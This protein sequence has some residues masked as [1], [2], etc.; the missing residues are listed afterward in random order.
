MSYIGSPMSD[1]HQQPL[2][3][4]MAKVDFAMYSYKVRPLLDRARG[5]VE[6]PRPVGWRTLRHVPAVFRSYPALSFIHGAA[7]PMLTPGKQRHD[8]ALWPTHTLG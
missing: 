7:A 3:L 1:S 8:A 5:Q 4:S 6:F 2:V